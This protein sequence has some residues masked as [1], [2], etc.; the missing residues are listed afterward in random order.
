M[1]RLTCVLL[2]AVCTS[3]WA[4]PAAERLHQDADILDS[5][6]TSD[7][8]QDWMEPW[9]SQYTALHSS[10]ESQ[11]SSESSEEP[12]LTPA[13]PTEPPLASTAPPTVVPVAMTTAGTVINGTDLPIVDN[14]TAPEPCPSDGCV[15]VDL[16]TSAPTTVSRG[17]N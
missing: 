13:P 6:L 16:P 3:A 9:R 2:W 14:S 10:S 8:D 7:L 12:A 17:D 4:G 15:T 1:E 11:E 5:A